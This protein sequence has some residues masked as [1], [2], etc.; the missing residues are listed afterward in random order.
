MADVFLTVQEVAKRL[1]VSTST[2]R[3]WIRDH[4][5]EG[6]KAGAQWRFDAVAVRNALEEGRLSVGK[7]SRE[8]AFPRTVESSPDWAQPVV[9]RWHQFLLANIEDFR[10][11]HVIVNDRRGAKIWSLIMK[12][13]FKWGD[14]LW[15]STAIELMDRDEFKRIFGRKRVLLFDE[16]MQ[17]GRQMRASRALLEKVE[18]E[19]RSFVCIR[20]HSY[21]ESGKLLDFDAVACEDLDDQSFAERAALVSRLMGQFQPPLDV[22]HLVIK[23]RLTPPTSVDEL[24]ARLGEWGRLFMIRSPDSDGEHKYLTITLD[25]PQFFDTSRISSL[26]GLSIDWSAPCKI[27]IYLNSQTG[28]C[29]CSFITYP[30][31]GG[32]LS[33]WRK[34]I[35]PFV[36]VGTSGASKVDAGL[37]EVAL[38]DSD[39]RRMYEATC[40]SFATTL[41]SDFITSGAASD[42]G[43][44]FTNE[45]DSIDSEQ[46]CATFGLQQGRYILQKVRNILKM[47]SN[48]EILLRQRVS[49]PPDYFIRGLSPHTIYTHDDFA[50]RVDLLKI[51]PSR[52]MNASRSDNSNII[53][54]YTDIFTHLPLY[55][56]S[57]IGQVLDYEL[58]WGTIQ[59]DNWV[60]RYNDGS[61][62]KIKVKRIFFRGEYGPWFEWDTDIHTEKDQIIQRSL[63][64]GPAVVERF[65]KKTG[66]DKISATHFAKV[67]SNL[68][69]D[70]RPQH[71]KLYIGWKAYKYGA[72]PIVGRIGPSGDHLLF[73]R[74]LVE[75]QCLEE[76]SEFHGSRRWQNYSLSQKTLVPWR[77]AF[78]RLDPLVK[79][80]VGGLTRF[81]AA[82]QKN[83]KSLRLR[84]PGGESLA[85][86][87]DPLI[88]LASSRNAQVAYRCAWFEVHDWREKGEMLFPFIQLIALNETRPET[89]DLTLM[90]EG[91]AAPSRLLFDKIEM[92][93]NL[94]TLR[95]QIEALAVEGEHDVAE[96]VL[97]TV[98]KEP[99]FST[100]SKYPMGNL[101]WACSIIR[102]FTSFVR[103]VLTLYGLDEDKRTRSR[104]M[105]TQG[106]LKDAEFYLAEFITACPELKTL[107][108]DLSRCI[109]A[110]NISVLSTE[111]AVFLSRTFRSICLLFDQGQRIPDPRLPNERD[112]EHHVWMTGFVRTF[113]NIQIPQPYA[114]VVADLYNMRHLVELADIF[115]VNY[116]KAVDELYHWIEARCKDVMATQEGIYFSGISGDCVVLAAHDANTLLKVTS[117]LLTQT[118]YRLSGMDRRLQHFALFRAGIAWTDDSLGYNDF[119]KVKAGLIAYSIGDRRNVEP[120]TLSVTKTIYDKLSKEN[121]ITFVEAEGEKENPPLQGGVYRRFIAKAD[122]LVETK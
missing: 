34:A 114:I 103:Q 68:C 62:D 122:L 94:P 30:Q 83:C 41:F 118:T 80:H 25:R 50:C 26:G 54:T 102:P 101:K 61:S 116:D 117:D 113:Q 2:V 1:Q 15:H 95:S 81:Y 70:W 108:G 27:R 10:P 31:I 64:I 38:E 20:R 17:Y 23:G 104:S 11:A 5:L 3:R 99:Q 82:I 96:I 47:A 59:P 51:I 32:E 43:L 115:G 53:L 109:P 87:S 72:I 16:M 67:F 75:Q 13:G 19:V 73:D 29:Y 45:P 24:V 44:K 119:T 49:S 40:F 18:A 86:F 65:L 79:A 9:G 91:F 36:E 28:D 112:R 121:K 37:W 85:L 78:D 105:D 39:V 107:Q 60:D 63:V 55:S 4:K 66:S 76:N 42:V 120:G 12:D 90:L 46:L 111:T 22:D 33:E 97:Q 98:D 89:P 48:G 7:T 8:I 56:E 21:A 14:N 77:N 93:R 58:D 71:G 6:Q 110:S 74:F 106:K 57:T 35:K 88:V 84:D 92:Y 69:H 52:E 100:E